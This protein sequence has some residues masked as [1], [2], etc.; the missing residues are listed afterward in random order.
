MG[1][2]N[3]Y[4]YGFGKTMEEAFDDACYQAECEYGM[5]TYNGKINNCY[6]PK[7][8]KPPSRFGTKLYDKWEE[9]QIDKLDKRECIA[10]EIT[11]KM[12]V[13]L[14]KRYGYFKTHKKVYHFF[15]VAPY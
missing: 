15:G 2:V 4:E 12:A 8:M 1:A 10:V 11:G 6:K 7:L 14:K 5:D 9:K 3:T 13:D